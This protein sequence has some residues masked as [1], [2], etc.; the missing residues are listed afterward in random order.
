MAGYC[1]QGFQ[2]VRLPLLPFRRMKMKSRLE[3]HWK[4]KRSYSSIPRAVVKDSLLEDKLFEH[5]NKASYRKTL[6]TIRPLLS[7][8]SVIKCNISKLMKRKYIY[9][10]LGQLKDFEN[11]PCT[12]FFLYIFSF[13]IL[14]N[15]WIYIYFI[16]QN[17]A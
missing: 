12:T 5:E 15:A 3:T 4:D 17:I 10:F 11:D 8:M 16:L 1:F 14:H 13:F 2:L 7:F 9:Y 6:F